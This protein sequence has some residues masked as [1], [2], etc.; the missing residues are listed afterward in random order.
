MRQQQTASTLDWP[1][2]VTA[3]YL[4]GEGRF[5]RSGLGI[6]YTFAEPHLN[7]LEKGLGC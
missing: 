4:S 6:I 3:P 7:G 1:D 2:Q 5:D